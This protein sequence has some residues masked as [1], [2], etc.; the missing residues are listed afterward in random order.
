MGSRR[1]IGTGPQS[2]AADSVDSFAA[3]VVKYIP[4]DV[5]AAWITVSSLMKPASTSS[6]SATP[7]YNVL[8]VIFVVFIVLTALWT[9]RTTQ[10][11]NRSLAKTQILVSTISFIVWVFALGGPF[12][13]LTAVS[14]RPY[15]GGI[16]LI[17]W[18]LIAGLIA[19]TKAEDKVKS[20]S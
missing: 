4:A 14:G 10:D 9:W 17:I 2:N 13:S 6:A 5:V 11:P 1:V 20:P 18:T 3:K 15:L 16:V 19:P 7:D 12:Q 8:W